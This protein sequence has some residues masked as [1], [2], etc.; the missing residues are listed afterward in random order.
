MADGVSSNV[1]SATA[2]TIPCFFFLVPVVSS[3]AR[4]EI[5]VPDSGR[6]AVKANQ[7]SHA[8]D[9]GEARDMRLNRFVSFFLVEELTGR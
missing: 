1:F 6:L 7:V 9:T 3:Q 8:L 2:L 5:D 4:G